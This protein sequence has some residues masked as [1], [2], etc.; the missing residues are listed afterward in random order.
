MKLSTISDL[1]VEKK[2]Y[3]KIQ[4]LISVK[5]HQ[6][7]NYALELLDKNNI[8]CVPV[9]DNSSK[10]IGFIDVLDICSFA[11]QMHSRGEKTEQLLKCEVLKILNYSK[12][13]SSFVVRES[14]SLQSVFDF[15]TKPSYSYP[16][17]PSG[18]E[19]EGPKTVNRFPHRVAVL[20]C[21][22]ELIDIIS[23]WDLAFFLE[24]RRAS[25]SENIL[26]SKIGSIK[27]LIHP[28][29]KIRIDEMFSEAL[30][31]MC[32]NRLRGIAVVDEN[33]IINFNI[34]SLNVNV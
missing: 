27:E 20:N 21:N 30:E 13:D 23:Q 31:K 19:D 3:S 18:H 29:V 12:I 22:E 32:S 15:F 7:I 5:S 16:I 9:I 2:S 8:L 17:V 10:F 28:I 1:L 11:L 25:L 26:N 4:N 24:K 34:F 6:S 14:F 33:G